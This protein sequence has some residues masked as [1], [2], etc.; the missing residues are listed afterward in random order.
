MTKVQLRYELLKPLNETL[1]E[2]IARVHTV[3]GIL[4]VAID[5]SAL[6]RLVVEYDASRLSPL[7][8]ENV[9]HRAG[10]PITLSV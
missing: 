4:R 6:N 3:Y 2:K 10:L 1:M 7:E 5:P 9:L 8:V